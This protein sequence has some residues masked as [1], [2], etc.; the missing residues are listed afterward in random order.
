VEY[1][2]TVER[3]LIVDDSKTA[4][5]V[6][7]NRLQK[8]DI[9]VAMV[10]SGEEALLYLRDHQPG[11]IFMDHMMPGMDGFEAVKAIRSDPML[12]EIPVV[13]HTTKNGSMYIGQAKAL[14]AA[15]IYSKPGSDS[16][17]LQVLERL[18]TATVAKAPAAQVTITDSAPHVNAIAVPRSALH[19]DEI[20]PPG[21]GS[22]SSEPH[23]APQQPF[24]YDSATAT[25]SQPSSGSFQP[26]ATTGFY[27]SLRQWLVALI[28]LAPTVWLLV[29]YIPAQAELGSR[30]R[31]SGELYKTLQWSLNQ[32]QSYD[33]GELALGGARLDLLKALLPRLAA[34]GFT[35]TV[36]FEGHVGDFCLSQVRLDSGRDIEMLPAFDVALAECSTIGLGRS[37]ALAD[38]VAQSQAFQDFVQ[39]ARSRY[40]G[41]AI[42]SVAFGASSPV[43][44]YPEILES[45]TVGQWNEVALVN[46]RINLQLLPGTPAVS[47]Q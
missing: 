4:R 46:N 42:D 2:F 47:D 27:G 16:E 45:V 3:A 14:G 21:L 1:E 25:L 6:L 39:Q 31:E 5:L 26:A 44:R 13:M 15:D 36:R 8:L 34:A 30:A 19:D 12:A 17:L 10:E 7:R 32:R 23:H 28:W 24:T 20:T 38:S 37:R 29:L 35:G 18:K 43:R 40:P 22:I 41:I 9:D 11:V 33:F